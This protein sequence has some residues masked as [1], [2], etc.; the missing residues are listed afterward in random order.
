MLASIYIYLL[1]IYVKFQISSKIFL[2]GSLKLVEVVGEVSKS[3]LNDPP[4]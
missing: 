1:T 4:G 3:I 2:G